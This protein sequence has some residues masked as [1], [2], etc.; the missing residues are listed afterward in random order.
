MP[1]GTDYLLGQTHEQILEDTSDGSVGPIT[2]VAIALSQNV[3]I[4]DKYK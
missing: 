3:L 4:R 1:S 2:I